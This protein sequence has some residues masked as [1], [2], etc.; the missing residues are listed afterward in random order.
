M[1]KQS[2]AKEVQGYSTSEKKQCGTCA[3]FINKRCGIGGF[4]VK[5]TA[6]CN[7]WDKK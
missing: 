3:H 5:V 1:S 7:W 2:D 6:V 4:A